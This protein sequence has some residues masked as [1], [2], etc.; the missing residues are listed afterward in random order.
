MLGLSEQMPHHQTESITQF[1]PCGVTIGP[2]Q[3]YADGP[4]L[5]CSIRAGA[6]KEITGCDGIPSGKLLHN[7]GKSPLLMGKSTINGHFQ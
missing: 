4:Y 1:D 6:G 5:P 7:Y 2:S 3:E